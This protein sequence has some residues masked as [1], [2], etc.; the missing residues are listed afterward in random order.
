MYCA[1]F[2]D[3]SMK[4]LDEL[5]YVKISPTSG[6]YIAAE[7]ENAIGVAIDGVV[8]SVNKKKKIIG[9]GFVDIRQEDNW[10]KEMTNFY[11][12]EMCKQAKEYKINHLES[13]CSDAITKGRKIAFAD[14]K[15][16]EFT[17]TI[18]DQLN[19]AEL[20]NS[21]MN[22]TDSYL[23]HANGSPCRSYTKDE[24]ILIYKT[25]YEHKWKCLVYFNQLRAY[26]ESLTTAE[27]VNAVEYGQELTGEYANVYNEFVTKLTAK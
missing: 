13:Q 16:E 25:L 23:Y 7:K 5:N 24:I 6:C 2:E 21:A 17:Y 11:N 4:L 3:G 18:E 20:A 14:G 19:I 8:Y 27:E 12:A 26:V 15:E 22:G 9:E 1:K 10:T